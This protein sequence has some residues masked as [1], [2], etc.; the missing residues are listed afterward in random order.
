MANGELRMDIVKWG[1]IGVK[2]VLSLVILGSLVGFGYSISTAQT[3]RLVLAFYY[4]T[5]DWA[6]WTQPLADQP[7]APYLSTHA[8]TIEHHVALAQQAGIDALVQVWYGPN[9]ENNPTESN[10]RVLL[11][12]TQ[13]AGLHAGVLVDMGNPLLQDA[14]AVSAALIVIREQHGQHPAYLRVDNRPVVF[15]KAQETLSL[16][17]WEALRNTVDPQH[18]LIWVAEGTRLE[19]LEIFDG[20]YLAN[21]T[22]A[23]DPATLLSRWGNSVRQWNGAHNTFRYWIATVSPGYA[24]LSDSDGAR[25]RN[26]GRYYRDS[27]RGAVRSAADWVIIASFN[28]WLEGTHIESSVTYGDTYLNLTAEIA[29]AY[30][31]PPA[32]PTPTAL[33][34]SPTPIPTATAAPPTFTP[35]PPS[36]VPTEVIVATATLTPTATPM[37][38]RLATP[39][40]TPAL[41][42]TPTLGYAPVLVKTPVVAATKL[43]V[44]YATPLVVMGDNRPRSCLPWPGGLV[45]LIGLLGQMSQRRG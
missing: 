4:A 6:T 31:R 20:L 1:G 21:V 11:E 44:P 17:T 18:T 13:A 39:T 26:E 43:P 34:P 32:T 28:N 12:A 27:W 5:F 37:Q 9:M 29:A 24:A 22:T 36:P 23:D 40:A 19:Y 10:F 33:P 45:L 42:P 7:L 38:F 2:R 15:F 14:D 35:E 3:T 16:P 8:A 25:A 41:L 30:R